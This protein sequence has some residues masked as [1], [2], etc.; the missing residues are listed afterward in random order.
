MH[1]SFIPKLC[2]KYKK[3]NDHLNEK[4][5]AQFNLLLQLMHVHS[6]SLVWFMLRVDFNEP[7]SE[8]DDLI[9][10][11]QMNE[12]FFFLFSFNIIP[13]YLVVN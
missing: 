13:I 7:K 8:I 11:N 9:K 4:N 5:S 3:K 6:C 12:I 1:I 2:W 10:F